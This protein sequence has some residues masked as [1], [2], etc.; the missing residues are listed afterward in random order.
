MEGG[1]EGRK[2]GSRRESFRNEK[3]LGGARTL[4][5]KSYE[6]KKRREFKR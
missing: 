6:I 1:V 3:R 4:V 5:D 2:G